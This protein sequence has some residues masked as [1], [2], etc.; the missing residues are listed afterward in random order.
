MSGNPRLLPVIIASIAVV[1]AVVVIVVASVIPIPGFP[2]LAPGQADGRLVYVNG[3]NCLRIADLDTATT[4]ELRCEDDRES[5]DALTWTE[6]G[7]QAVLYRPSGAV[8][9]TIDPTTGDVLATEDISDDAFDRRL[10]EDRV[11]VWTDREEGRIV[12]RT[13]DGAVVFEDEAPSSYWIEYGVEGPTG[14]WAIVDS[15][16]RLAILDVGETPRLVDDDVRSWLSVAWEPVS[17]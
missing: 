10:G 12:V 7:I 9:H 1:A 17:G 3:D 5:F 8:L 13:P 2:D 16:G 14:M 11:D 4:S 6:E 15:E